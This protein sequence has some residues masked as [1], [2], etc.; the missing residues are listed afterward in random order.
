MNAVNR[1][2]DSFARVVAARGYTDASD[3]TQVA[4]NVDVV[5]I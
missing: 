3:L 2:I 1:N 4:V 5:S